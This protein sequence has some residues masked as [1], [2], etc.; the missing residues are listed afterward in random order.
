MKWVQAELN[1]QLS[2]A[3]YTAKDV[4]IFWFGLNCLHIVTILSY[5]EKT[6]LLLVLTS[7]HLCLV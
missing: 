1:H 3:N 5:I 6:F 4:K 7:L 2:L